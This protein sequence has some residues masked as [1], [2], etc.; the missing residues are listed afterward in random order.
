[1]KKNSVKKMIGWIL[2]V[3]QIFA[4]IGRIAS[5]TP[6]SGGV[7]GLFNLLGFLLFGIIGAILIIVSYKDKN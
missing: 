7:A 1:M 3:L 5:G 6:F 2:V 4:I